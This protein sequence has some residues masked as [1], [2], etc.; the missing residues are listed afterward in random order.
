MNFKD[1]AIAENIEFSDDG[2]KL[3][4]LYVKNAEKAFEIIQENLA[5]SK[6]LNDKY[7]KA[8][9]EDPTNSIKFMRASA[10]NIYYLVDLGLLQEAKETLFKRKD[11]LSRMEKVLKDIESKTLSPK[12]DGN[13]N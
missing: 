2:I 6:K 13:S 8:S 10:M 7:Q 12:N 4:T 3:L 5:Y 11:S 1:Q 9:D